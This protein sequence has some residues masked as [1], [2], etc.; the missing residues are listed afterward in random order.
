MASLHFRWLAP[1]W[2][3]YAVND[4]RAATARRCYETP[5]WI[6]P[7]RHQP[8][9]GFDGG[10]LLFNEIDQS[11]FPC[12]GLEIADSVLQVLQGSAINEVPSCNDKGFIE[13]HSNILSGAGYGNREPLQ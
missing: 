8:Q 13:L 2:K 11:T 6:Y 9:S 4:S 10:D 7:Q 1:S 12:S 3:A 5:I